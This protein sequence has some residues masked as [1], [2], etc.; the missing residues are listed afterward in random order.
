M[1][2]VITGDV[3]HS[4]RVETTIWLPQLKEILNHFGKSPGEWELY[5]GDSFQLIIDP[6][7]ALEAAIQI[8]ATMKRIRHLGVRIGIGIGELSYH[9]ERVTES[10][11]SAFVHSGNCFDNLKK[12]TL[13]IESPWQD[14]DKALNI[15][16]ALSTYIMDAWSSTIAELILCKLRE[17]LLSQ[18]ELARR[19]NKKSQST[20]SE[21]LQRGGYE[22]IVQMIEYYKERIRNARTIT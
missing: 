16:C 12:Q 20:I 15:M 8:K 4:R 6:E 3:I 9:S 14:F 7:I 18:Q 19:L 5:R 11:G 10:N 13:A 17:P 2:A 1:K 22:V 21:G